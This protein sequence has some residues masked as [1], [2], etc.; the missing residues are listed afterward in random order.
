MGFAEHTPEIP[1]QEDHA[2]RVCPPAK[3]AEMAKKKEPKAE[4]RLA[5]LIWNAS[6]GCEECPSARS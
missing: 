2:R 1:H 3:E 4:L 5:D 6:G